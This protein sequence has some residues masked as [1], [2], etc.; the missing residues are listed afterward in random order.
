[1]FLCQVKSLLQYEQR[2]IRMYE[3]R[4]DNSPVSCRN[5]GLQA[6]KQQLTKETGCPLPCRYTEYRILETSVRH[7]N[8]YGLLIRWQALIHEQQNFLKPIL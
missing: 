7:S 6:T 5:E 1:M 2:N 8:E 3:V 4:C